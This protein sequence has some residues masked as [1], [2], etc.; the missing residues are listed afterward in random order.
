MVLPKSEFISYPSDNHSI[1]RTPQAGPLGTKTGRNR[2][3][4][5]WTMDKMVKELSLGRAGL[6]L[7]FSRTFIIWSNLNLTHGHPFNDRLVLQPSISSEKNLREMASRG[8]LLS[9]LLLP[10]LCLSMAE[11]VKLKVKGVTSIAKTDDNFICATLDW[12]PSNKCDYNQCPWGKAGLLNLDLDNKILANAI[13]GNSFLLKSFKFCGKKIAAFNPLRLRIG[14]SLQ[15]QVVYNVRASANKCPHFKKKKDGLFGFSKGCLHMKRWDKINKLFKETG[16]LHTFGFNALYGRKKSEDDNSLWEGD[17]DLQNARDLMEYTVS[18]G[19]KID[20]YELGFFA[21]NCSTYC[22][23]GNELSGSGVSARLEAE[24]YGKDIV[25]LKNLVKEV[26]PD[27]KDQPKVLGPAGFYDEKWFNTFLKVSGPG[28]VDGLTH[29]VYNLGAGV[30]SNLINKVQDPFFLDQIAQTFKD[31][32]TTV[33]EFGPWS[34]AWVGESGGAYNSGGK[35]V[36]HTFVNGFW[37]LDQLGMTSTF[38]HKVYCRQA[39]IGGNYAL[40]NTTTFIPNPDYYGFSVSTFSNFGS[41]HSA[42]LW[43]RL[44]GKNVLSTNHDSSPNLRAYSHCSKNS[45]G[46]TVLLI[47]MSNSTT[48]QVS[49]VDDLNL[50]PE[51]QQTLDSEDGVQREEYHLTPKD[52]N[53]Q[54]DVLLLNGT[55]LKLTKSLNIPAL[56]PELVDPTTPITVAPD[57][58]VFATLKGFRAPACA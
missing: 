55:P 27:P 14:G 21:H 56:N 46:I 9:V 13:K 2:T 24:Q 20:S 17:W 42:L 57:S 51:L 16:V 6:S 10:C 34:G 33:K 7:E 48:F 53:I 11:E 38:N 45:H 43:H 41:F 58:I 15:D 25:A 12:W 26:Y 36:S 37:Y 52:G 47:N 40:L 3:D 35:D 4:R 32:S 29:H 5:P 49:V 28:V 1:T 23:L 54:S 44:M 50:Y 22:P 8:L 31:I 30:D 39:F 18:K 19:Y